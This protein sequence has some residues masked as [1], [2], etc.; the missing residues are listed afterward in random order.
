MRHILTRIT[1]DYPVPKIYVTE[2]GCSYGDS[3]DAEG[4]V[5]DQRRLDYLRKHFSS[6]YDAMQCGVP[7]AGY[8]VWSLMD[9]FE[10]AK[11]Y[12]DR[13]G[14]TWVDFD[15]QERIAKDSALWYKDVIAN[16]GFEA[17]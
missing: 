11:G 15:T 8:F 9:N 2:N 16:D 14:I 17:E 1:Y 6:A 4:R 10:W 7:L 13:F 12:T 5:H 3:P